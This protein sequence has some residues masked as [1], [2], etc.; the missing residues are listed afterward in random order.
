LEIDFVSGVQTTASCVALLIWNWWAASGMSTEVAQVYQQKCASCHGTDGQGVAGVYEPA[1]SGPRSIGELTRL[2]ERTMPEGEPTECV[3]EQAAQVADYIYHEFYSPAARARKGLDPAM[4]VELSRMTVSQYRNSVADVLRHFT[5]PAEKAE[6]PAEPGLTGLYYGS[7]GMSKADHLALSRIDRCIDFDF[8]QK[9]PYEG[10]PDDQFAIV[11]EGALSVQETGEYGLRVTTP[12]GARVYLNL[13]PAE[14]LRKLRDDSAAAGQFPLIDAWVG[15][16]ELREESARVYLLGGR[17]Y[18]LRV[19]YFKY[20]EP[21]ASIRLEWK[22][23]HGVWTV[24]GDHSLTTERVGRTYVAETAFPAD[25]RSIG[26]ERGAS[27]SP[28]WYAAVT[29]G[30]VEAAEEVVR[31]LPLLAGVQA[32]VALSRATTP[33]QPE[34]AEPEGTAQTESAR[35]DAEEKSAD[36]VRRQRLQ[37]FIFQFAQVAYRR[38]LGGEQAN[39]I[40]ELPFEG[41]ASLEAAVRRGVAWILCSPEF[42]YTDLTPG[43]QSPTQH[44]IASRLSMTLWDSI[45]DKEL[46]DAAEAG[47]LRTAEE[48]ELQARRLLQ[49]SRTRFKLRG[50]FRHWLHLEERDTTKDQSL[51]PGFDEQVFADLRHSL[52][53]FL[54]KVVWSPT[55]DY[56]QLLLSEEVW[57]NPRLRK[58]YHEM[59][60]DQ[61]Q[62]GTINT[63]DGN[64]FETILLEGEE[65]A[66][67]LTHPYL[68]SALAYHNNTSPIHRGVFVTRNV[69]GRSL[70]APP[71]A[72]AFEE[73]AF[74]PDLTMRQKVAHLTSDAS[75]LSCHTIIN[76]LGFSLEHFDAVGRRREL[77]NGNPIDS[78]SDYESE[79]GEVVRLS[80]PRD[81]AR[82]AVQ[83][84]AARRAFV[85]QLFQHL[86]KQ[87][88][89]AYGP[90]VLAELVDAFKDDQYHIQNLMVRIAVLTARHGIECN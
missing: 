83:S 44:A 24:L 70:R 48:V 12:N 34:N 2:I 63:S 49:D 9:S 36:L 62:A 29:A 56:R 68:L 52:D 67:V 1:L 41:Q 19:E 10:M 80:S 37:D 16:G 88:P 30:A 87:A 50:F 20:Q 69:L 45:P 60:D 75:C 39:Q 65:R 82:M 54:E 33:S 55:S 25:D 76:P 66:G 43:G 85:L 14:G 5:P 72:I 11:W 61:L 7:K 40:R 27:I 90:N 86:T 4:V 53:L 13:D 18:P 74:P 58:L 6:A 84:T 35:V 78:V 47:K 3:G 59:T 73:D 23:P 17:I 64:R 15:S 46:F 51:F 71:V 57:L 31:R 26:F 21:S 8:G 32:E 22:T 77:E 38:P 28:E 89:A 42:L 81:I 79:D